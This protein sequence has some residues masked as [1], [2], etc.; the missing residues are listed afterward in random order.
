MRVTGPC[1]EQV[2]LRRQE[3][4]ETNRL[5]YFTSYSYPIMALTVPEMLRNNENAIILQ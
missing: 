3:R 5:Y 2:T 4:S 1:K